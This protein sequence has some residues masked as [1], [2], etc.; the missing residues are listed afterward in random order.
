[1]GVQVFHFTIVE[2]LLQA[3]IEQAV[4]CRDTGS[5]DRS[6]AALPC[7]CG[8]R[9]GLTSKL[10]KLY[11]TVKNQNLFLKLTPDPRRARHGR[12]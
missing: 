1:M 3:V 9:A 2:Q 7:S 11:L 4:R 12:R 5:D 10:R 8:T 6:A